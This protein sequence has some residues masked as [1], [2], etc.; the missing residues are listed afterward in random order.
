MS[1][2]LRSIARAFRRDFSA[3]W[4][5]V[6]ALVLVALIGAL[7]LAGVLREMPAPSG[8]D[9]VDVAVPSPPAGGA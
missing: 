6:P 9:A 5:A 3:A 2:R 8:T 7:L 4:F 1:R